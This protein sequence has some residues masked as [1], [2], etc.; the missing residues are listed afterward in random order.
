MSRA[1]QEG[2]RLPGFYQKTLPQRRKLISDLSAEPMAELAAVLDSGGL[3]TEQADKVVEN[4]IGTYSLPFGLALN[5]TLNGRDHLVPMV[6]EEPSVIAAA[7]GAAKMIREGGGFEGEMSE[8]LLA[9]QIE[10]RDVPVPEEARALVLQHRA[11][12]L[13]EAAVVLPG[14]VRRGAGPRDLEVRVIGPHH[15]VV[16]LLVD[17]AEAM[18]ANLVNSA[19]EALS[20]RIA[21]LCGAR[22]GLRILSN[23]ADRR[24]VDLR[25]RVPFGA[26]VPSS[27]SEGRAIAGA[28]EEASLFAEMDPYRA[29][30]HNKGIMNGT[31]SLVIATGNDYRAV[32]AGAHAFA[33][34]SGRYLPLATWRVEQDALVGK[35]RMPL[36]LGTVGGTLKVHA[37]AQLALRL[38][39]VKDTRELCLLCGAAGLASNL[40]ALRALSTEGIQRGHM[41]LHARS[42]ATGAGAN[43]AE[44]DRVAAILAATGKVTSAEATRVLEE[45]RAHARPSSHK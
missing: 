36:S 13:A 34:Q 41:S 9:A 6:V 12:L 11:E 32:E 14:L 26:L 30:T 25:A 29:A 19:A 42:V 40:A 16:H 28:I 27:E 3:T 5:F 33:A 15:V 4:V 21:Q 18:G 1:T 39:R 2:S 24:L 38:A 22:E 10:L 7:S 23:L 37:A 43:A 44:V 35:L 31:D 17:C 8:S 45:I 20:P